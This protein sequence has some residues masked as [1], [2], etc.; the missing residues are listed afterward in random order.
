[1]QSSD[2]WTIIVPVKP[3]AVGKSRLRARADAAAAIALDTIEAAAAVASVLVVGSDPELA[4]EAE[5]IPGVQAVLEG[6][7]R[8]IAAAIASGLE[9]A[10]A[11]TNVAVLLGDLPALRPEELEAALSAALAVPRAFV[12]DAEGTGTT[13]VT[14]RAGTPLQTAFGRDSAA[15]HE[16]LGLL[17]LD[18]PVESGLRRD[19][20]EPQHLGEAQRLGLGRRSALVLATP[21]L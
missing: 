5:A 1:M 20:D 6:E 15:R 3:P 2:E 13:L 14:A 12:P 17:R 18:V 16:A 9:A 10:E 4:R 7:S 8:G 11:G 19:V 21:S